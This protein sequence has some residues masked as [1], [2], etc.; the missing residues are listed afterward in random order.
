M[1]TNVTDSV[2]SESEDA[3]TV[4][5]VRDSSGPDPVFGGVTVIFN[6]CR[7]LS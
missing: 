1:V 5:S 7:N 6:Q 4:T 3:I 2:I